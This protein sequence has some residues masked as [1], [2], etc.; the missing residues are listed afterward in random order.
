M[1]RTWNAE[2]LIGAWNL[3]DDWIDRDECPAASAVVGGLETPLKSHHTGRQSPR[4]PQPIDANAIFLI[5]SPTKPITA[6]AVMMLVEAGELLLVDP[7]SKYIPT[8]GTHGKDKITLAHC[9]THTSGL[10]DML[11]ENVELRR[12]H[13]PLKEFTERACKLAPSFLPGH[14]VQY[15]S[16]GILMLAEVVETVAGVPLPTFLRDRLFE[17]LGMLDTALGMPDGWTMPGPNG[18][19]PRCE[20]IAEVRT[21]SEKAG[22]EWTWAGGDNDWGWNSDYWRRLGAP[23]G[24][25]LSTAEDLAK[26]C[27]HLLSIH[28]GGE[29]LISAAALAAMTSNQFTQMPSVPEVSRRCTPWALGWQLNWPHDVQTFGDL[30]S[31]SAYGHWGATGTMLWIDPARDLFTVLLTTEPLEPGRR[32]HSRFSN[33]VC[34]ALREEMNP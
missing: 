3:L 28:A 18:E 27:R 15:Q 32:R 16:M 19:V 23:W 4:S 34:G 1:T 24:G 9:L 2:R 31:A 26:L 30:L 22:S 6:L 21:P 13:A 25:L 14:A 8:F 12:G 17:P 7:I 10:P 20:R 29:G 11:P 5:A 33:A